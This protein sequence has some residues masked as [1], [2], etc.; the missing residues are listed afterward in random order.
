MKNMKTFLVGS[1]LMFDTI[2]ITLKYN[3][4]IILIK[5]LGI[6]RR[7]NSSPYDWLQSLSYKESSLLR[8]DACKDSL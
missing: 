3:M 5:L 4:S 6:K 7:K 1:Q 8:N 2:I